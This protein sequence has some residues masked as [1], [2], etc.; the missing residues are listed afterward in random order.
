MEKIRMNDFKLFIAAIPIIAIDIF[1]LNHIDKHSIEIFFG[2]LVASSL[3]LSISFF[4][5]KYSKSGFYFDSSGAFWVC[6]NKTHSKKW[7]D[8]TIEK[9]ID[10]RLLKLIYL[11]IDNQGKRYS[12]LLCWPSEDSLINLTKKYCPK[13]HE[14]YSVVKDYT[15][16]RGIKF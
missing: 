4:V 10:F 15:E 11:N 14:L 12:L 9:K 2:L 7:S 6:G 13:D 8:I 1:L 3:V 5:H 16:K